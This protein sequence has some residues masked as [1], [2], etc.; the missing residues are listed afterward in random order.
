MLVSVGVLPTYVCVCF[1]VKAG[2]VV[3]C[4]GIPPLAIDFFVVLCI[5][6]V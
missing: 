2:L 5:D 6:V 3:R 4:D 1:Q